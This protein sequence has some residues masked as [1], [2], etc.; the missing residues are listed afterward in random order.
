MRA[1]SAPCSWRL[2][3]SLPAEHALRREP[4]SS[5]QTLESK[6]AAFS[7]KGWAI[8]NNARQHVMYS[9]F[10]TQHVCQSQSQPTIK[11]SRRGIS[12]MSARYMLAAAFVAATTVLT[13]TS[14][15]A[16]TGREAVGKCIDR[17]GC[18]WRVNTNGTIDIFTADGRIIYCSD[19][20][21]DCFVVNRKKPSRADQ[22]SGATG[23]TASQ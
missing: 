23:G 20:D 17:P 18:T 1:A 10:I 5:E 8:Q 14:A 7:V 2:R 6:W 16:T 21:G 22:A 3:N 4:V 9:T 19:A 13:M 15:Q 11:W 12:P